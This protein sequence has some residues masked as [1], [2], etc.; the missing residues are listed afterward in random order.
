MSPLSTIPRSSSRD[1]L[2]SP[3]PT[4]RLRTDSH[5]GLNSWF[6]SE[7]HTTWVEG[8]I[9]CL[10]ERSFVLCFEGFPLWLA[11]L[12]I[13]PVVRL[14]LPS[15]LPDLGHSVLNNEANRLIDVYKDK[16]IYSYSSLPSDSVLLVSGSVSFIHQAL[17]QFSSFRALY[18]LD[19]HSR[20]RKL[21]PGEHSFFRLKHNKHGGGTTFVTLWGSRG[22]PRFQIPHLHD[23]SIGSFIEHSVRGSTAASLG[24]SM[25]HWSKFLPVQALNM[26]VYYPS[27]W[28]S[29][30]F[31]SRSLT[32]KELCTVLG[33]T[34]VFPLT[35]VHDIHSHL[36]PLDGLRRI[37][38]SGLTVLGSTPL[39]RPAP[40][41]PLWTP[42]PR[43][44]SHFLP[45]IG[46]LLP[47]SWRSASTTEDRK[48]S[49]KNDDAAPDIAMWN[50][51]ITLIRPRITGF[52]LDWLRFRL[53]RLRIRRLRREIFWMLRAYHPTYLGH[54]RRKFDI[55]AAQLAKH[56]E[57]RSLGTSGGVYCFSLPQSS[58]SQP[59]VRLPWAQTIVTVRAI[60]RGAC[61]HFLSAESYT[62]W[63]TGSSL[64]FWRWPKAAQRVALL[65]FKPAVDSTLPT[66]MPKPKRI[67]CPDTR[68]LMA[69]KL[70][71]QIRRHYIKLVPESEMRKE[72][73]NLVDMFTVPKGESDVRMI[74]NGTS[75][76]LTDSIW[77]P[78]FY[79]P[80]ATSM[81]RIMNFNYEVV[82][83][84]LGE[85]FNNFPLCELLSIYSGV[86]LTPVAAE[87][88]ELIPELLKGKWKDGDRLIGKWI[89]LWMGLKSSPEWAARFYYMAEEVVRG[90]DDEEDNVLGWQKVVLNIIG[91]KDFNPTL[92]NV[93]KWNTFKNRPAGDLRSYVDDLRVLGFD[94]EEAWMI[95]R[96]VASRLQYLGIQ[97][98]PRKRRANSDG[99][100]AGTIFNTTDSKITRTVSQDKW[101][102]A[103]GMIA[104]LSDAYA[105]HVGSESK[106]PLEFAY[107]DLEKQRGFL[108]HLAMT[109]PI[110]FPYLKGYHLTLSSHLPFRSED[111]W[112]MKELEWI[113]EIESR[114]EAG[115]LTR[116][117]ADKILDID[118]VEAPQFVTPVPRFEQCLR[119]L[120]KFF[121]SA[122]PPNVVDR[123]DNIS[124]LIYGFADASKSGLGSIL[125]LGDRTKYRIGVWG[126]DSSDNSSNWRE[127]RNLVLTLEEEQKKGT[128]DGSFIVL[129]TDNQV[130]ESCIYKGNSKSPELF[131][132]IVRLRNVE[133]QTGAKIIV[134]HVSGRRMMLQGTDAVSRG[135]MNVGTALGRS[136]LD[137]CPW[138]INPCS[139]VPEL[140]LLLRDC[141]GSDL[142][143][144]E[145]EGWYRRGHDWDG[146]EFDP[147]SKLWMQKIKPGKYVWSVPAGAGDAAIEQ[148]RL[149][150]LKRRESYH[151]FVIPSLLT[152]LWLKQFHKE[153]DCHFLIPPIHEFWPANLCENL[154]IGVC[155]PFVSHRPWK[156]QR[157]P[158]L[159]SMERTVCNMLKNPEL[160]QRAVLC[161]FW[162]QCQRFPRMSADSLRKVLYFE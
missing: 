56:P 14:Y 140:K 44:T 30:G 98:A 13:S 46:A 133:L 75:G 88:K 34:T 136:L 62:A 58:F 106:K 68:K 92:P 78:S 9:T 150:R 35:V 132:L 154:Y 151:F 156:L 40:A 162:S 16:I 28:S 19:C 1:S 66:N 48:T 39:T 38:S 113:G 101:N 112:K 99:P 86:D 114:V 100:W 105:A 108:C 145:P 32:D 107:K 83:I 21:P 54:L 49:A 87:L 126:A 42:S 61:A 152:P 72:V 77:A 63:E 37:L 95:A 84:D 121:G 24:S 29:S 159:L 2:V 7:Q 129:A 6:N 82:D 141:F 157:T 90:K 144:L 118:D 79:L 115:K 20:G 41:A 8:D 67:K 109:F 11:A 51:R 149:A 122:E 97:D 146:W 69:A 50:K 33:F 5:E 94:L 12:D 127:F 128:L 76:G 71:K 148:L 25:C 31:A 36:V 103:K 10:P 55:Y 117:E 81:V 23:R 120:E 131:D 139:A 138:A 137:Y 65:G 102:K 110:L 43:P 142:E 18:V 124:L 123:S 93:F 15:A 52:W 27:H 74:F 91:T 4:K 135:A 47:A 147:N 64:Y 57:Y 85:M 53:C 73:R 80:S 3:V 26:P 70:A 96:V 17:H 22:F 153:V 160:D 104:G 111:G 45:S 60:L 125:D 89:R 161:E 119:A 134:T 143:F 155:L 116:A 130:A 59:P 158:K